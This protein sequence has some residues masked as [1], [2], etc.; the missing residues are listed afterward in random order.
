M[1]ENVNG[2]VTKDEAKIYTDLNLRPKLE[3]KLHQKH[4]NYYLTKESMVNNVIEIKTK[5][6]AF[7]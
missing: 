1:A 5:F 3:V 2:L 6:D 4:S 7:T